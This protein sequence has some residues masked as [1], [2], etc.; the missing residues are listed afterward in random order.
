MLKKEMLIA[1]EEISKINT[2]TKN[3]DDNNTNENNDNFIVDM[4][5]Q[6]LFDK[7]EKK[8]N[9]ILIIPMLS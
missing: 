1:E 9:N 5:K 2:K 8:M 3:D 4:D 7:K 6:K